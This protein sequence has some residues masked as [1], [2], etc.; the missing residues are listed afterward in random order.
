[1]VSALVSEIASRSAFIASMR[2]TESACIAAGNTLDNDGASES[3]DEVSFGSISPIK[4]IDN[5]ELSMNQQEF[6]PEGIEAKL[7]NNDEVEI[8]DSK[9]GI[10]AIFLEADH[11]QLR[12]EVRGRTAKEQWLLT[13]LK[14]PGADWWIRVGQ[15]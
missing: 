7:D 9:N 3:D 13:M 2:T 6:R 11:W 8:V 5:L 10:V 14:A 12:E 15:A 1:M 4:D